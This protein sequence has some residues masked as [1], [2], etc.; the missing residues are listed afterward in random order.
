M[1]K[2][3]LVGY[4]Y[5]PT[6]VS[7]KENVNKNRKG[8]KETKRKENKKDVNIGKLIYSVFSPKARLTQK[9]VHAL[10]EN[11]KIQF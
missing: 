11:I 8:Y 6:K 1:R 10:R 5:G 7:G 3:L 2:L 9:A 4:Q